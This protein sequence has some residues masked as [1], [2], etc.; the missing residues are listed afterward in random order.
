MNI[1]LIFWLFTAWLLLFAVPESPRS[2]V[3]MVSNQDGVL[4]DEFGIPIYDE[5]GDIN[6]DQLDDYQRNPDGLKE[7]DMITVIGKGL[8]FYHVRLFKVTSCN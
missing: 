1:H 5:N 7:G 2:T 4:Q 3:L 8:R 6:E